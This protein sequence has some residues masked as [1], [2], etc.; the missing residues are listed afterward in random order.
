VAVE[1][2]P[3][4]IKNPQRSAYV[5]ILQQAVLN[6]IHLPFSNHLDTAYATISP[7]TRMRTGGIGGQHWQIAAIC[8]VPD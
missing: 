3:A 2:R 1:P 5:L 7:Q 6:P 4:A 8:S